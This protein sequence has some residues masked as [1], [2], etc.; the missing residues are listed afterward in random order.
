MST[1]AH[2][3]GISALECYT[4]N[5]YAVGYYTGDVY[6]LVDGESCHCKMHDGPVTA[7]K[8]QGDTLYTAGVDGVMKSIDIK[9]MK[10]RS[11]MYVVG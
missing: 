1:P 5:K 9:K 3:G 8:F 6:L 4:P 7:V 2:K 10:M 11:K